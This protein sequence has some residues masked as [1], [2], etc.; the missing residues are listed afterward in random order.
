MI[1][2]IS[3]SGESVCVFIIFIINKKIRLKVD[4]NKI[5]G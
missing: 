3:D 1:N 2:S 5:C 4:F